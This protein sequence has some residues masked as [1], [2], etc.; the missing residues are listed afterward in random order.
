MV[1]ENARLWVSGRTLLCSFLV[2]FFRFQHN[3]K[4]RETR[5]SGS[6]GVAFDPKCNAFFY[7]KT[8]FSRVKVSHTQKKR[9]IQSTPLGLSST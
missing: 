3:L 9:T 1:E 4:A 6:C 8:P 5:R 2:A 7:E